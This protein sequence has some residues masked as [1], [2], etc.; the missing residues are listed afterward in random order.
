M[1]NN[2]KHVVCVGV[3][4]GAMFYIAKYFHFLGSEVLGFDINAT[5]R[6][7]EL[8]NLG[9]K[10]IYH[11]PE[12]PFTKD[13]NLI[14]YSNALPNN[15]IEKLATENKGLKLVSV[16]EL[17]AGVLEDLDKGTLANPEREAIRKANLAPLYDIDT[18]ELTLIGVT[19]TDGK[20]TTTEMVASILKQAGH[21]VGLINTVSARIGDVEKDTGF[22]VTTPS[23]QENAE[24]IKEMISNGCTH[25]VL[26]CT[27]HGL[28]TGRLA[29]LKLDFAVYTNIT[30]EHLDFHK[31]MDDLIKSK[32]YLITKHLK[33]SGWAVIN[34]DDPNVYQNMSGLHKN[35]VFY[36][37]TS[38]VDVYAR[39]VKTKDLVISF[40]AVDKQGPF[41]LSI[42]MVGEYNV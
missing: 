18:K 19:G 2:P 34:A 12:A 31:T 4:G 21:K 33:P 27:S 13:T 41:T 24:Y 37:K 40:T 42:P 15:I 8:E 22:H 30:S 28:K 14:V 9:I 7:T 38:E 16:D 6:T 23:A 17:Y 10:V 25:I 26:E 32:A 1:G 3:G 5:E 36:S 29:G 20:T 11:N 39:E 35:E